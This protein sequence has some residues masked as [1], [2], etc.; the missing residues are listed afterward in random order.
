MK[1][2]S[3]KSNKNVRHRDSS[4]LIVLALSFVLGAVL[5]G[6]GIYNNIN[7]NYDQFEVLTEE[8]ADKVVEEKMNK[9]KSL[10][11]QRDA[12]YNES[13]YSEKYADLSR[14]VTLAEGEL[15]DAEAEL[16]NIQNGLYD[17]L[18]SDKIWSS[19]PLIVAGALLFIIGMGLSMSMTSSKK[20]NRILTV[21]EE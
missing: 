19:I 11:E 5:I 1:K 17:G 7:S 14:Q 20:K 3:N 21:S 9:V 2:V 13:A 4:S 16:Y 10:R 15:S 12:E 6:F 8:Q 18:K